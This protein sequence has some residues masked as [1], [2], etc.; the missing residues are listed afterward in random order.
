MCVNALDITRFVRY[1][2]ICMRGANMHV[3]FHKWKRLRLW[4]K[5]NTA[6]IFANQ[7][8]RFVCICTN[9]RMCLDISKCTNA[10]QIDWH[11][12]TQNGPK[13]CTQ[14]CITCMEKK[15]TKSAALNWR[16]K[17]KKS[18]RLDLHRKRVKSTRKLNESASNQIIEM[19][20]Q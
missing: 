8:N 20:S 16:K 13:I 7:I 4:W 9:I 15:W 11:I 3:Q 5:I 19:E 14:Q 17:S 10:T 2:K 12:A 6:C 18:F 1:G